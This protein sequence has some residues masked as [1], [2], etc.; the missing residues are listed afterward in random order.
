MLAPLNAGQSRRWGPTCSSRRVT[1]GGGAHRVRARRAHRHRSGRRLRPLRLLRARRLVPYVIA[2]QTIPIVALAPMIVFC[3][4]QWTDQRRDHRH[5]PDASSRSRSPCCAASA[6]LTHASLELMR[7]YAAQPAGPSLEGALAG[8]AAV[9]VHRAENRRHGEHRRR[10]RRRG[11]GGHAGTALVAPSST[12][13]SSTSSRPRS[14][15]RRSSS[16]RRSASSSSRSCESS[17][18]ASCRRWPEGFCRM[19]GVGA[20]AGRRAAAG[21]ARPSPP[22]RRRQSRSSDINLDIGPGEFVSL[23]G[24]SGCGK[25]HPA[26]DR[27]AT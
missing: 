27:S 18:C 4:G 9:P 2:S 13:T 6:R 15:G 16:P 14:C 3:F 21:S 5:L 24:P 1:R 12:S 25:S 19:S 8:I 26:A 20:A 10:D 23:I 7:S 17:S 22:A 11:A